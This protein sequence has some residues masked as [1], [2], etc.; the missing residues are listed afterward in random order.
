MSRQELQL[1][2]RT[3]MR[4]AKELLKGGH[5]SGAYYLAGYS[6]ECGLKACIAKMTVRHDFPDKGLY[7]KFFTHDLETLLTTANLRSIFDKHAKSNPQF[8]ANWKLSK[9]WSGDARYRVYNTVEAQ[10]LIDALSDPQNGVLSW[11]KFH[12]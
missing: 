3:R 7:S 4:E 8:D 2:S 11:L 10:T 1:L 6:V 9:K 5:S 12:W